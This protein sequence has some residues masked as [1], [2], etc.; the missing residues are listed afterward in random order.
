MAIN[1]SAHATPRP[2][3]S[4]EWWLLLSVRWMHKTAT[5]PTVIEAAKPTARPRRR[6]VIIS[7]PIILFVIRSLF[8]QRLALGFY[9]L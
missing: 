9:T 4:P 6:S 5:G 2:E 7:N 3:T 8:Y 1:V